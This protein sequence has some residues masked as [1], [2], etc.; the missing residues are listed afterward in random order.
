MAEE[1]AVSQPDPAITAPA[2]DWD[3]VKGELNRW[4]E[5]LQRR[6][7]INAQVAKT[8][9]RVS[10]ALAAIDV[11]VGILTGTSVFI[12]LRQKDNSVRTQLLV[13]GLAVLPAI[14][15]GLQ[16]AW[17]LAGREEFHT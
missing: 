17:H 11:I 3:S 15:S 12:A 6:A 4:A 7:K 1:S 10:Q 16:R 2:P 14:S 9:R 13:T 5:V 8:L